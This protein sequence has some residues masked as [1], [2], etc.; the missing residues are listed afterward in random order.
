MTVS[1]LR[2]AFLVAL[3]LGALA[4][5]DSSDAADR[6]SSKITAPDVSASATPVA[7]TAL[8]P[9]PLAH[10]HHTAWTAKD[11][12][13]GNVLDIAQTT[14]GYLWLGTGSGLV[15]FD[16][17]RFETFESLSGQTLPSRGVHALQA[18]PDNSLWIGF[19]EGG[20]AQIKD[21]RVLRV[22]REGLLTGATLRR[23]GLDQDGTLWAVDGSE[24]LRFAQGKWEIGSAGMPEP[25]ANHPM[26]ML[27]DR[28][29][30]VW[31]SASRGLYVKPRRSDRFM[32]VPIPN[33]GFPG[34][35]LAP[36]GRVWISDAAQERG[37]LR[38]SEV[39][40]PDGAW[41]SLEHWQRVPGRL[42]QPFFDRQGHLWY[43]ATNGL[44]RVKP[45]VSGALQPTA[46]ERVA[47]SSGGVSG[48]Y[49][50]RLFQDREGNVW[51]G[52]NA[53]LD[54]FRNTRLSQ[55]PFPE[56]PAAVSMAVDSSGRAWFSA[57]EQALFRY[58]SG[59]ER[60]DTGVPG[61][62]TYITMGAQGERWLGY[63]SGLREWKDGKLSLLLPP[64]LKSWDFSIINL[65]VDPKGVVWLVSN[66]VGF[67]RYD[68]GTW[69]RFH[70]RP[71]VPKE[72]PV[73]LGSEADGTLWIGYLR[74][75]LLRVRGDDLRMFTAEDGLRI[76]AAKAIT[77]RGAHVWAGGDTGIQ[78]LDLPGMPL[79]QA[80]D[81]AALQGITGIVETAGGDLWLNGLT[82]V[83][84]ITAAE[85][86]RALSDASYRVA[87]TR[88]DTLDGLPAFAEQAWPLRTAMET[89]D[90]RLWFSST[91]GV[92]TLDPARIRRNERPPEVFLQ[93]V[94]T[95]E[96]SFIDVGQR[97]LLPPGTRDLTLSYT[98]TNLAIPER[99]RF[100][101]RLV[102]LD[103]T[104]H[105][106]EARRSAFYTN[107]GPGHYR[108]EVVA[109]NEDGVWGTTPAVADIEIQPTLTER[110]DFRAGI[111]LAVL[112][113][114]GLLVRWRTHATAR[115]EQQRLRARLEE[116]VRV[117]Q[118][119]HDTLL[120]GF[121][122]LVLRMQA[123]AR[124]AP[125]Q[126]SARTGEE[127][128]QLM[129]VAD[130]LLVEGR[131][132][133]SDLHRPP[134]AGPLEEMLATLG[135]DLSRHHGLA[136][137]LLVEGSTRALEREMRDQL[138]LVVREALFNA[139]QHSKGTRVKV[140]VD[141]QPKDLLVRV[142]DDGVGIPA[143]VL[144]AGARAGH[145]GLPG[146]Q[147]R[148][149]QAGLQVTITSAAAQSTC[150][151]VCVPDAF[152]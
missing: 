94:A 89:P 77:T 96:Q 54:R 27:A 140:T 3:L 10:L 19:V 24:V 149:A 60:V 97:L 90:G 67:F 71:G 85:V 74:G 86:Q 7:P 36:D 40:G 115:I 25:A 52:T 82:G 30:N 133:I 50:L 101:Y 111:A 129:E 136:F 127:L 51:V 84:H 63:R 141:Y 130:R 138:G 134:L 152:V 47:P 37:V 8:P 119:L 103:K 106:A 49:M 18:M 44:A 147:A 46:L 4:S 68:H 110:A 22:D 73:S 137:E 124:A 132:R 78:R 62:P 150:V 33:L 114:V 9:Q 100:R 72:P 41:G 122:G 43:G 55:V 148:A 53:G 105:E 81:G 31:V 15:R 48:Y 58:G 11:G 107:L 61:A 69:E 70:Q 80:R 39:P 113:A 142:E 139:F 23:F 38:L 144:A 109:S 21:G 32:Q 135:Q 76:G 123:V 93:R 5:P 28:A 1:A 17:V 116:R 26:E 6:Q 131:D 128:N 12:L 104:W 112:I 35:A 57:H 121:L 118:D 99:I 126:E 29:G 34:L 146:M 143:D 2:L 88:Y 64:G 117:A 20:A 65:H 108:F 14:D 87:V 79:L 45:P 59:L 102:G 98:A 95:P 151:T 13:A 16:G 92:V 120:Q 125:R 91:N 75:R 42:T 83:S 66:G 145:W 56:A